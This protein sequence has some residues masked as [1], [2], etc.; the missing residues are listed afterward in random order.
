MRQRGSR[1]GKREFGERRRTSRRR[2]S[3]PEDVD[4]GGSLEEGYG[5]EGGGGMVGYLV[6]RVVNVMWAG[7]ELGGG[8]V[9]DCS[10]N[11]VVCSKDI[12][13]RDGDR[14]L[15]GFM[16]RDIDSLF[17]RIASLSRRLCGRETTHALV[18][19]KGKEKE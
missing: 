1:R 7:E 19:K 9:A 13:V 5:W 15:P 16:R 12:G 10:S 6:W 3:V 2:R 8:G 4:C 11:W 17:G 18:E 14:L